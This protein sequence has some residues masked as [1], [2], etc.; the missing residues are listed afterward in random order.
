[1]A[2]SRKWL[3]VRGQAGVGGRTGQVPTSVAELSGVFGTRSSFD[4]RFLPV[5]HRFKQHQVVLL[6]GSRTAKSSMYG[7]LGVDTKACVHVS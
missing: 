2:Q 4:A 7:R 5:L 1:M 3:A 6:Q